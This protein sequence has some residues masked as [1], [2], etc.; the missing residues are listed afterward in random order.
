VQII[1]P[2]GTSAANVDVEATINRALKQLAD[3]VGRR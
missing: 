3:Q 2:P 1:F